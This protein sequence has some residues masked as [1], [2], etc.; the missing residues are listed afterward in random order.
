MCGIVGRAGSL[1]FENEQFFKV[2][3]LL[4]YLRGQDSTGFCSVRASNREV[5]TLKIA[6]D[7][8]ILMNHSDFDIVLNGTTDII[9]I[10]HNRAST[11]GGSTRGN[12]HPFTHGDITGVH[13]GT[14]TKESI[15]ALAVGLPEAYETDSETIF[16][17]ISKFG[18]EETVK[19]LQGAWALV[20]YDRGSDT[21]NMLRNKERP[22]YTCETVKKTGGKILSWASEWRMLSAA[23]T[24]VDETDELVT[25]KA[26][27]SYFPLPVDTLHTWSGED[28]LKGVTD[29]IETKPMKGREPA[30]KPAVMGYQ[31]GGNAAGYGGSSGSSGKLTVVSDD[32]EEVSVEYKRG[33]EVMT[34]FI[35]RDE[36]DELVKDGCGW[37]GDPINSDDEG[38]LVHLDENIVLCPHCS[39]EKETVVTSMTIDQAN[40]V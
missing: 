31:M 32:Y 5:K 35:P 6:D 16:A 20:W 36:W 14:L 37:C 34:K 22:L 27:F 23:R 25:D 7:P 8:I 3:L 28:L 4:D 11:V 15:A 10:G 18:I 26:G 40:L 13:N 9:W 2:L 21:L 24:M 17:H 38:L 12:A 33:D 39:G 1:L 29:K 30:P 19:K